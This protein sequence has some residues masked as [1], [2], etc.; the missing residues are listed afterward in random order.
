MSLLDNNP[1]P[2]PLSNHDTPENLH[3]KEPVHENPFAN[4]GDLL[5]DVVSELL[6]SPGLERIPKKD[7]AEE[8]HGIFDKRGEAKRKESSYPI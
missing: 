3:P 5:K 7:V 6:K 8:K 1:L 2:E 4:K